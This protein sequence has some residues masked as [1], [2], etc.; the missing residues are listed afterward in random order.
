MTHLLGVFRALALKKNKSSIKH[1]G[2]WEE[3]GEQTDVLIPQKKRDRNDATSTAV[4]YR[5]GNGND[6]EGK[7]MKIAL[8]RKSKAFRSTNIDTDLGNH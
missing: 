8:L 3:V 4:L 5:E 1:C 6:F 7:R 2:E